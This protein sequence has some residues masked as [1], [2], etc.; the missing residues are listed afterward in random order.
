ME[1]PGTDLTSSVTRA[2]EKV[3]ERIKVTENSPITGRHPLN[4][5]E[6]RTKTLER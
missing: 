1:G 4:F 5:L 2:S 3:T 6:S